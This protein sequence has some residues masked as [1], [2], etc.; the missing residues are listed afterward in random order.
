MRFLV[1]GGAGYIGSHVVRVLREHGYEP[2]V[3]DDLSCGHREFVPKDVPFVQASILDREA[4][5]ETF[6]EHKVQAVVHLAGFKFAGVSV[7][8]PL[9]TYEQ[10]VQGTLVL[11]REMIYAGVKKIVF[12]SSAAVYGLS[13][14]QPL[15]EWSATVPASPYGESKLAAE[16]LIS[17]VAKPYD[18]MHTSLRYFNV[19]GSG[20]QDLY[21]SSPHNL[22][23][24]VVH[25]LRKGYAPRIFGDDYHTPD[26]TCIRDYV[27]VLDIAEAHVVALQKLMAGGPIKT[28]YNLGSGVGVS[29]REVM[30]A[31]RD[32]SGI[33]FEA[34]ILERRSGDPA[35]VVASGDEAARDLNWAMRHTLSDM[36][37]SV[38]HTTPKSMV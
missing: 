11:L 20:Y 30:D 33:N 13:K 24:R 22:F 32:R 7:T 4:L 15:H 6:K 16:W 35:K 21:D 8:N 19:V 36:V 17:D 1:T 23:P 38:L 14:V 29:T 26:G 18:I 37:D 12:S 9:H 10:N 3:I 25:A 34:K 27:H 5:Y 31:F 2:V 28:V